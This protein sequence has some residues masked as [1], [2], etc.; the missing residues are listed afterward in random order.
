[1]LTGTRWQLLGI[2]VMELKG[3]RLDH[4]VERGCCIRSGGAGEWQQREQ[5]RSLP[6]RHWCPKQ[7]QTQEPSAEWSQQAEAGSQRSGKGQNPQR[8]HRFQ[9]PTHTHPNRACRP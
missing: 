1:M 5:F 8:Q 6:A 2:K 9:H 3:C 4:E 7:T